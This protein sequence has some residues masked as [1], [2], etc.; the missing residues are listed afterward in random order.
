VLKKKKERLAPRGRNK[1]ESYLLKLALL[2]EVRSKE[3][4]KGTCVLNGMRKNQNSEDQLM[5]KRS[6]IVR[7]SVPP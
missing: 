5:E 1:G 6:R 3:R 4:K 7:D 2:L